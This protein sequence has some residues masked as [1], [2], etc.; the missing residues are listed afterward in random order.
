[1]PPSDSRNFPC[2]LRT[3][4]AQSASLVCPKHP[5]TGWD[6]HREPAASLGGCRAEREANG[7]KSRDTGSRSRQSRDVRPCR[8]KACSLRWCPWCPKQNG[9]HLL[10][11]RNGYLGGP[12]AGALSM[13]S[14]AGRTS[15]TVLRFE[16]SEVSLRTAA[17]VREISC[18]LLGHGLYWVTGRRLPPSARF[19]QG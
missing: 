10:A 1:M 15:C 12:N 5:A 9:T 4:I 19:R 8:R 6:E 18:V 14:S 17:E 7:M 3:K 11:S 13:R 2:R 16:I